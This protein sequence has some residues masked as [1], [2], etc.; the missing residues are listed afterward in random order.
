MPLRDI[1]E[2]FRAQK[3]FASR[4]WRRLYSDGSVIKWLQQASDFFMGEAPAT[5]VT[6]ATEYF[7]PKLYLSV[8]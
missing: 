6:P 8:T 2:S 1:A 3:M 4:E 5:T 7:D